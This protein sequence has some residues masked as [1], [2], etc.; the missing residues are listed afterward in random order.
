MFRYRIADA[1]SADLESW[2]R[3]RMQLYLEVGLITVA[4][5]DRSGRYRDEYSEH[6]IH[7]LGANDDGVDIGCWHMI[8]PAD[9]RTLPVT[10]L[11]GIEILPRAYESSGTAIMREY[12]KSIASL[13]S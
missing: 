13:G 7:I 12:R 10:D 1:T 4:D 6:S 11:F 2:H 5:L 3:L 9:G 8:E